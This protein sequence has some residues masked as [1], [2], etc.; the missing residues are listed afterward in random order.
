[1]RPCYSLRMTTRIDRLQEAMDAKG[2]DQAALAKAAGCTQGA[3]SQIML[4]HTQRSKFLPEIA[5]ALD[6]SVDW[7]RGLTDAPAT[8]APSISDVAKHFDL[9]LVRQ[10]ELGYSMGGGSVFES[11]EQTG[12][13]PF[14]RD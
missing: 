9:T 4:G 1:M 14:Q 10:L 5:E 6:V 3:I 2:F 11:Y 7:L 13:V 8:G 12:V